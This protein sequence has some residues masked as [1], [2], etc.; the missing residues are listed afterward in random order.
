MLKKIIFSVLGVLFG[1]ATVYYIV[2][3]IVATQNPFTNLVDSL[4][5]FL[6]TALIWVATHIVAI[7]IVVAVALI[8]IFIY[9]YIK[10]KKDKNLWKNIFLVYC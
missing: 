2:C 4:F 8:L 6:G 7:L 9:Y 3:K 10:K 5:N 1:S